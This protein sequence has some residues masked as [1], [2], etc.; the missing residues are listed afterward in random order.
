MKV[1]DLT[2]D[3]VLE[4]VRCEDCE[5]SRRELEIML[6]AAKSYVC[7][8]TGL[9]AEQCDEHEDITIAVLCLC[10]DMYDNRQI[11]VDKATPNKTVET[12]LGMHSV[13]LI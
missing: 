12:I 11:T 5:E 4:F 13:N 9:T 1:S 3:T 8:Y 7:G 2:V 6:S 10:S